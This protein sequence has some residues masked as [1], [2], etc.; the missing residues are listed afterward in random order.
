MIARRALLD[1]VGRL[2]AMGAIAPDQAAEDDRPAEAAEHHPEENAAGRRP[3]SEGPRRREAALGIGDRL[4]RQLRH[5]GRRE[6]RLEEDAAERF[7]EL[8]RRLK[9]LVGLARDRAFEP[10]VEARRH[11]RD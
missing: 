2:A 5:V 1:R 9:P 6:P 3:A 10:G 8:S 7:A 11:P 4:R